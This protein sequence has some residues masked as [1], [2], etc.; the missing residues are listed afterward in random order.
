MLLLCFENTSEPNSESHDKTATFECRYGSEEAGG[1]SAMAEIG[2]FKAVLGEKENC[3]LLCD[4]GR[5][6][7]GCLDAVFVMAIL[8]PGVTGIWI[9]I[10]RAY[11]VTPLMPKAGTE[12]KRSRF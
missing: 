12:G 2:T 1:S 7:T 4:Q 5:V 3:I 11:E 10:R 6:P 9:D 8:S